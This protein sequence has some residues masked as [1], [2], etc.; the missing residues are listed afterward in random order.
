MDFCK[1]LTISPISKDV[2]SGSYIDYNEQLERVRLN[3]LNWCWDDSRYNKAKENEY[4]AFYF[5]G[6]RVVIHRILAVKPTSCR[7]PSWSKNVG[8]GDRNVLELSEPLREIS[9]VDWQLMNGPESKMGTYTT[10]D[11]QFDRPLLYEML[12][13]IDKDGKDVKNVKN[14]KK[15]KI[16]LSMEEYDHQ[17][18][19]KSEEN[20]EEEE[21]K[22]MKRLEEIKKLKTKKSLE[23]MKKKYMDQI[24]ELCD[25]INKIDEELRSFA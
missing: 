22:L 16:Y 5:H 11:L 12:R 2:K 6:I 21:R 14:V 17:D 8:Q 20:L 1:H 3:E 10:D 9:W 15:E 7:L 19:V 24:Q 18:D 25:K 4:F 13:G 23:K